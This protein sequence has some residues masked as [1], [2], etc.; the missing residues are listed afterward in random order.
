MR[1]RLELDIEKCCAC[2]ACAIACMDQHD[3][4][5]EQGVTPLRHIYDV[6]T[7]GKDAYMSV[8]CMHCDDAPCVAGCPVGG[9]K[10][11]PQTEL[12]VYDNTN[13]SA[14]LRGRRQDD[15]VRWLHRALAERNGARM[16]AG[17]SHQG[18]STAG[19]R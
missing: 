11:D 2:G 17:L 3:I 15:Q 1:L 18:D 19:Y 14:I 6:E 16:C 7:L 5:V 8:S 13:C 9:M 10:K 12:T 4:D